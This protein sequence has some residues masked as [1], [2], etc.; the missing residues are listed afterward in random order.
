M[1]EWMGNTTPWFQ[2]LII[3]YLKLQV[4]V[5]NGRLHMSK[6]KTFMII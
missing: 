4:I 1:I 3:M 6:L 5:K 2:K